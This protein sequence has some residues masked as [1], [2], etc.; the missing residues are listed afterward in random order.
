MIIHWL[1]E[2]KVHEI[3][4]RIYTPHSNRQ[5]M[6]YGPLAVLFITYVLHS[7]THRL[8]GMEEWVVQHKN[9]IEKVAGW[10][11][12]D[13]EVTDDRLGIMMEVLGGDE[14]KD[15]EC[16]LQIGGHMIQ[17]HDLPTEIGRKS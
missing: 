8:S 14:D 16:Q 7:L 12:G 13:K 2:M 9:V 1:L 5:G 6:S 3:I 17:A 15:V 11:V 4:D 10:K